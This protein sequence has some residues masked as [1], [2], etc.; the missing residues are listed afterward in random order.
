MTIC[1]LFLSFKI[2]YRSFIILFIIVI[3]IH[4][5]CRSSISL[6]LSL[7]KNH[8][9]LSQSVYTNFRNCRCSIVW[10]TLLLFKSFQTIIVFQFLYYFVACKATISF[11]DLIGFEVE[12]TGCGESVSISPVAC[13]RRCVTG[14]QRFFFLFLL[15]SFPTSLCFPIRISR[16]DLQEIEDYSSS[17]KKNYDL[18]A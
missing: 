16:S 8:L 18:L 4:R 5:M 3:I 7:E 15:F 10:L 1:I 9:S 13:P 17:K 11:F 2:P 6:P 14:S 12:T